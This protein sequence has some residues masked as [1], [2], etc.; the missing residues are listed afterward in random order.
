MDPFSCVR[1]AYAC[2]HTHH[3]HIL[4]V[5]VVLQKKKPFWKPFCQHTHDAHAHRECVEKRCGFVGKSMAE[6]AEAKLTELL[7]GEVVKVEKS[8]IRPLQVSRQSMHV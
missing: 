7:R 1:C 2:I 3:T 5:V 6:E 4:V 8:C